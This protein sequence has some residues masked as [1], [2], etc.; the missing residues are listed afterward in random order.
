MH[1][2]V[3]GSP[4]HGV[5]GCLFATVPNYF[6]ERQYIG[7]HTSKS[8]R[9]THGGEGCWHSLHPLVWSGSIGNLVVVV[10]VIVVPVEEPPDS[11]D[12]GT[13]RHKE[14][15]R[16]EAIADPDVHAQSGGEQG[17]RRPP[18]AVSVAAEERAQ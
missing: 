13:Q 10:V 16:V 17:E 4:F 1:F 3:D 2:I 8:H 12:N 15:E 18:V 9:I 6:T 11:S 7:F 14:D 5:F